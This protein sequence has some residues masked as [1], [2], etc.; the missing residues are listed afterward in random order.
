MAIN[1]LGQLF[2]AQYSTLSHVWCRPYCMEWPPQLCHNSSFS[3]N[4]SIMQYLDEYRT[5]FK[6]RWQLDPIFWKRRKSMYFKGMNS[7]YL[8]LFNLNSI[9][10][11]FLY[12]QQ[13]CHSKLV[14]KTLFRYYLSFFGDYMNPGKLWNARDKSIM[15]RKMLI[16]YDDWNV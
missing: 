11:M 15:H 8:F 10:S 1:H 7:H 3:L 4:L 5:Y 12:F 14:E 16:W 2:A 9:K 6:T 13:V